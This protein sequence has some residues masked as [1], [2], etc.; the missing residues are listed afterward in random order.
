MASSVLAVVLIGPESV[1]SP[2]ILDAPLP[3]SPPHAPLLDA[4]ETS[5][6]ELTEVVQEYCV[7]CHSDS[8][9]RGNLS[10]ET[11]DVATV[12]DQ[13]EVGERVINKLRAAM[14]PPPGV[15]RPPADT[16]LALVEE[17]EGRID[18]AAEREPE[19][20]SRSFQRLNR[21]EYATAV[22]DLLGLRIDAGEWLPLDAYLANFDNMAVAQTLSAT[23][24]DA[25]LT[26][27]N[28][29]SRLAL[30]HPTSSETSVSYRVSVYESS[31]RGIDSTAPPSARAA[32]SC[33][34]TTSP[35]TGST[36]SDSTSG[37]GDVARGEQLD[38]SIDGEQVAL[39]DLAVLHI[40]ADLGPNWTMET[41]PVFIPA[42]HHRVAAAF[43]ETVS[44][45]YD[46]ILEP[47]GSSLAGTR[48]PVG[49]GVTLLPHLR[50][51]T[52][53][54]TEEPARGVGDHLT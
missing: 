50:D 1:A 3:A 51:M 14:M 52:I 17:I 31:M 29:V 10:L 43:V 13:A 21:V 7:R 54:G 9:L 4:S 25:Y 45:P 40:D 49:Y 46:D 33:E 32:V 42:G 16:L 24:L 30:G 35:P 38:I 8:R 2:P 53:V 26:A 41:E 11:F 15:R 39:L 12:A 47:H 34:S 18:R 22:E 20:G 5:A 36:S 27:A 19:P 23:L 28:E 48:A 6:E 44:G 37:P